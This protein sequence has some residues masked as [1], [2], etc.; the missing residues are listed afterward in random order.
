[1]TLNGHLTILTIVQT[2]K[3]P[4]YSATITFVKA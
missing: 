2:Q 3:N 1:M 4:R